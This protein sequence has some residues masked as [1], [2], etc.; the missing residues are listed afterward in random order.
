[1]CLE[2]A[3]LGDDLMK[4]KKLG[5]VLGSG[6]ARGIAH[7]GVLQALV[8]NGL[9]PDCIV[10]CSAG[11]VVG[12]CYASGMSPQELFTELMQLEKKDIFDPKLSMK[13]GVLGTERMCSKLR[14]LIGYKRICDLDLPFRFVATDLIKGE[15]KVFEGRYDT[16]MA[17]AAS[18]CIPVVFEPIVIAGETFVDGGVLRRLPVETIKDMDVDVIVAVDVFCRDNSREEYKGLLTVLGRAFELMD[19]DNTEFKTNLE[20]PDVLI[21][22]NLTGISQFTFKDFDEI[23]YRG[24]EAGI[25]HLDEINKLME[26]E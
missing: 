26:S 1:M 7:V 16:V 15:L 4:K 10:G 11:A 8:E 3:S 18:S 6:A 19:Q 2:F 14:S 22:P 20:N 24:Y 21:V 25:S 17:V 5:L 23:Y 12:A 13:S 9:E